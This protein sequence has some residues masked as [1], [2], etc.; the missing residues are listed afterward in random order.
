M[1]A[2]YVSVFRDKLTFAFA[3]AHVNQ[4][5]GVGYPPHVG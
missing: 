3:F 4:P 1:A 5:A 2:Y